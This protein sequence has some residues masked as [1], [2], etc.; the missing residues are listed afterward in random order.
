MPR[1]V[2]IDTDPGI[3]DAL[4]ITMA[5]FDPTLEVLALTATGGN[6]FPGQ[7]SRNVQTIV[8]Q[9]DP[10][11]W[12]RIGVAPEDNPLPVDG[13]LLHGQNGLGN[14]EFPFAGLANNH[15]AEKV[16]CDEVRA[17][18]EEITVVCLGPLTNIARA[19]QRDS[20][21]C[22]LVG[23]LVIAGGTLNT[24]GRLSPV[25]DFNFL[26]DPLSARRVLKS[27]ATKTLIPLD[28]SSEL[29]FNF[30]FLAQLP[31]ESTRAGRFLRQI[32]PFAYRA[33]RQ[34]LAQEHITMHDVA[35]LIAV[36]NPEL[37][38]TEMLSGDVETEGELTN[39]MVVFD[40]RKESIR[41]GRPNLDV[42][43]KVDATA[44]RDCVLR[45][46]E[47]AGKAS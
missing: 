8:E 42:A 35:S 24:P 26:C 46:L 33:Q 27:S 45:S 41:E 38:E 23:R 44:M 3:D 34:V 18:P 7:A 30:D 1:K 22:S 19:M 17:A 9:L 28:V 39:G 47:C 25:A 37:F 13:R 11:R 15:P 10:P 21:F 20:E 6:V 43:L 14:V 40:R 4:A 29:T 36:T 12:P 32:L 16:L 5:L 2:I 31:A